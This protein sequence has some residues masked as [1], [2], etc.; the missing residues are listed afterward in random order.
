MPADQ[1][2]RQRVVGSIGGDGN[3]SLA[4]LTMHGTQILVAAGN[5]DDICARSDE[6]GG[7]R[8]PEAT[9]GSGDDGGLELS[10]HLLPS[11]AVVGCGH[12]DQPRRENPSPLPELQE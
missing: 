5:A 11:W 10:G 9:A 4:E 6:R 8:A 1:L 12:H 3:E 2:L 7:D